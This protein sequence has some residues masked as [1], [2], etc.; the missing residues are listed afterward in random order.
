M[1]FSAM[2][3]V[4]FCVAVPVDGL[5]PSGCVFLKG[6]IGV[7]E[8]DDSD[9]VSD[10]STIGFNRFCVSFLKDSSLSTP[11]FRELKVVLGLLLRGAKEMVDGNYA[12][13]QPG[14]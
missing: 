13:T 6:T 8:A 1:R 10:T 2:T 5:V 14:L 3:Y 4:T 12:K 9:I 11:A 7:V